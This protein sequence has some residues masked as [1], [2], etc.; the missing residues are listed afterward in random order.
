MTNVL[1]FIIQLIGVAFFMILLSSP[2]LFIVI[3]FK[4]K[5]YG[6]NYKEKGEDYFITYLIIS[7]C[8]IIWGYG[9]TIMI[10]ILLTLVPIFLFFVHTYFK[11]KQ[12]IINAG[13]FNLNYYILRG[14][15]DPHHASE[16]PQF[17]IADYDKE[18][19]A[20]NRIKSVSECHYNSFI[21]KF[22]VLKGDLIYES[23]KYYDS[24]GE[25]TEEYFA[26][27]FGQH[28]H[29][30][31]E[32]DDLGLFKRVLSYT[33]EKSLKSTTSYS[34]SGSGNLI[35][36]SEFDKVSNLKRKEIYK[37]SGKDELLEEIVF[38]ENLDVINQ[39]IN[40]YNHKG[41]KIKTEEIRNEEV[42]YSITYSYDSNS[43]LI[44]KNQNSYYSHSI[45]NY[46][47]NSNS[48][49]VEE[50]ERYFN[51]EYISETLVNYDND[52]N[53]IKYYECYNNYSGDK[54]T[55]KMETYLYDKNKNIR[56]IT[57]T[58]WL[59]NYSFF[60]NH[61]EEMKSIN[62]GNILRDLKGNIRKCIVP[63]SN[64]TKTIQYFDEDGFETEIKRY[65]SNNVFLNS[66]KFDK[67]EKKEIHYDSI[68]TYDEKRNLIK[69]VGYGVSNNE[70]LIVERIIEY[71]DAIE[72]KN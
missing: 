45:Q 54:I 8:F 64:F 70:R 17:T 44:E 55:A 65:D 48:K 12:Q 29:Y 2:L 19:R 20:K 51:E 41:Q 42:S 52:G 63:K 25:C 31:Y 11:K 37:Y 15:K 10:P 24:N 57:Y 36:L 23:K 66:E 9:K 6:N 38:D 5:K 62:S 71:H 18:M 27:N 53:K 58:Q 3:R 46:K 47:Y 26:G 60:I 50:V 67:V 59:Q 14:R 61:A 72:T 28:S 49:L 43:N 7:F 4:K 35:E 30:V 16:M 22:S 68:K 69:E 33:K 32:N 40:Q 39:I 34:Y 21:K 56:E 1:V 13:L